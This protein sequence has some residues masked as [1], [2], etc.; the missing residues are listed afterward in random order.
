MCVAKR[1]LPKKYY[2]ALFGKLTLGKEMPDEDKE[3]GFE[4]QEGNFVNPTGFSGSQAQYCQCPGPHEKVSLN[5]FSF[6]HS[7]L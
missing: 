5:G 7:I 3:W 2:F 6:L 1:E 4:T